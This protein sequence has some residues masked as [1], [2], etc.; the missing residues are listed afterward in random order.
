MRYRIFAPQHIPLVGTFQDHGP[1]ENDPILSAMTE[2]RKIYPHIEEPDFI[3]SLGTGD[4]TDAKSLSEEDGSNRAR[5]SSGLL[6]LGQLFWEKS[7][8][9]KARQIFSN[10]PRYLRF[11]VKFNGTEPRLDSLENLD[12]LETLVTEDE[13]LAALGE[14]FARRA[15][16]SLFYF[17]LAQ[18]MH[19]AD[20]RYEGK[21]FILCAL[22][23]SDPAFKPLV[24]YLEKVAAKFYVDDTF[25]AKVHAGIRCLGDDGRFHVP[26][27]L[28]VGERFEIT[29]DLGE[30][31]LF[32]ISASPFTIKMLETLQGLTAYFGRPNHRKRPRPEIE[33]YQPSKR[34]KA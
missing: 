17:E 6:R 16:A 5:V 30:T 31:S 23:P 8:D 14:D 4:P 24:R 19:C 34:I 27:Q 2:T 25:V 33:S 15:V 11:D 20:R 13:S 32:P 18:K 3:L 12:N 26:V 7:R 9:K 28:E 10:N 1:L 22:E 21:G 29:I